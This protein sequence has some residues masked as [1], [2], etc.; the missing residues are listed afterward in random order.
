MIQEHEY[1][2]VQTENRGTIC[3]SKIALELER[4]FYR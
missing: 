1:Y 3:F 2:E 4:I